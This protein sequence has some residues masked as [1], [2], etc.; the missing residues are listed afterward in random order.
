[1]AGV[2]STY[3]HSS[4]WPWCGREKHGNVASMRAGRQLGRR[5]AQPRNR[6]GAHHAHTIHDG[7]GGIPRIA[8]C[9]R[10]QVQRSH[11]RRVALVRRHRRRTA[12]R[13]PTGPHRGGGIAR[14]ARTARPRR[15]THS[16]NRSNPTPRRPYIP[17]AP[18]RAATV[19]CAARPPHRS[20]AIS[21]GALARS[22]TRY[23][24]RSSSNSHPARSA[25]HAGRRSCA[26]RRW[27]STPH[28]WNA[29][30]SSSCTRRSSCGRKGSP[31]S[32]TT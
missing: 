14:T 13:G 20:R 21:T 1:M 5:R 19:R 16:P 28:S 17:R 10:A 32:S 3:P 4:L 2:S 30:G 27:A 23:S 25:P 6:Q 31:S 22:T 18:A 11:G 12:P 29:H 8:R 26:S 15:K 7:F 9:A 24:I